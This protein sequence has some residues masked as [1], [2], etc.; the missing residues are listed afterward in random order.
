MEKQL[1]NSKRKHEFRKILFE[2]STFN[3]GNYEKILK[4]IYK[5]YLENK[6]HRYS[7]ISDFLNE[8]SESNNELIDAILY[9][10][11]QIE[12]RLSNEEDLR[13]LLEKYHKEEF[14]EYDEMDYECLISKL[15]KLYDHIALEK[16][17]INL[18]KK[19][20]DRINTHIIENLNDSVEKTTRNLEN[21]SDQ[22]QN[23]LN[24]NVISIVGIFSAIIFVFFGGLSNASAIIS[25]LNKK[26]EI[27]KTMFL[28]MGIGLVMFNVI[29][30]LLY[31]ISKLT[32]KNIGGHF[33]YKYYYSY[34]LDYYWEKYD[35]N[36]YCYNVI[37]KSIRNY[38]TD[39]IVK[40]KEF[41]KELIK[42][43]T[44]KTKFKNVIYHLINFFIRIGLV[45][46]NSI[47]GRAVKRYPLLVFSNLLFI[48]V[49]FIMYYKVYT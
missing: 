47:L 19:N 45:I 5:Y 18:S 42:N 23:N 13:K 1:E 38:E 24:T 2:L 6:R 41:N 26:I 33:N 17:R 37:K 22:I 27:C 46:Y 7:H 36:N 16:S 4:N 49:G 44:F 9:N 11:D 20:E 48:I 43:A 25:S 21:R 31:S 14:K 29:F 3:Q 15:E 35:S 10:I 39:E 8:Q 32:N 28:L 34:K 40:I 30:L 12:Y